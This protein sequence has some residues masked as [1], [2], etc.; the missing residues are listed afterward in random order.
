MQ[1]HDMGGD[2]KP[3]SG[4]PLN[5]LLG[6]DFKMQL[7]VNTI[8]EYCNLLKIDRRDSLNELTRFWRNTAVWRVLPP[9]ACPHRVINTLINFLL[10]SHDI[11]AMYT[12]TIISRKPWRRGRG[13]LGHHDKIYDIHQIICFSF[14][15]YCTSKCI[16]PGVK[17]IKLIT[18]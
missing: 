9:H 6:G 7:P 17:G 11:K 3:I 14:L 5:K 15:F 10:V 8:M 16:G 1:R 2:V 18:L 4:R 12:L 13:S